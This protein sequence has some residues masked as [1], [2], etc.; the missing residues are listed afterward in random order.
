[1]V[2]FLT[3]EALPAAQLRGSGPTTSAFIERGV[4]TFRD[5]ARF[6]AALP[7]GR[8]SNRSDQL[9]VLLE[10]KGTC[11]TKHALLARLAQEQNLPIALCIGIYEMDGRNTPGVGAV[12][13][14]HGL[15][16]IPEA[17]CYLK[18]GSKRFDV[19]LPGGNVAREPIG[20]VFVE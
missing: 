6:V 5:A 2:E 1:M 14:E 20:R 3:A 12:L 15:T 18:R 10:N 9:M 19:T 4:S 17:H 7:Y 13:E 16:S 8:N 11:S